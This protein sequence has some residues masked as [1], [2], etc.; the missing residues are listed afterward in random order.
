L[1]VSIVRPSCLFIPHLSS[2]QFF[3]SLVG[4]SSLFLFDPSKIGCSWSPF[5]VKTGPPYGLPGRTSFVD[6]SFQ[7]S[8]RA[9]LPRVL[10][11]HHGSPCL[12]DGV[13]ASLRGYV[14]L[15]YSRPGLLLPNL[16]SASRSADRV[17]SMCLFRVLSLKIQ[18]ESF[19]LTL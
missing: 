4:P 14:S 2:V 18:Q 6:S 7:L 3:R 13:P 19:S 12:T 17:S 1:S 16:G 8:M 15:G 11:G 10:L 9:S 5:V